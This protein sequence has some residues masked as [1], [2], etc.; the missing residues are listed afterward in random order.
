MKQL[1][2]SEALDIISRSGIKSVRIDEK[3][4]PKYMQ[5]RMEA[6]ERFKEL[7]ISIDEYM[8]RADKALRDADIAGSTGEATLSFSDGFNPSRK[9][10]SPRYLLRLTTDGQEKEFY[11]VGDVIVDGNISFALEEGKIKLWTRVSN[12]EKIKYSPY[13]K[14]QLQ[15]IDE[16]DQEV[17]MTTD[18]EGDVKKI[19]DMLNQTFRGLRGASAEV[20]ENGKFNWADVR[21]VIDE[22]TLWEMGTPDR[23][24]ITGYLKMGDSYPIAITTP[25]GKLMRVKKPESWVTKSFKFDS[26]QVFWDDTLPVSKDRVDAANK[27]LASASSSEQIGNILVSLAK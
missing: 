10:N 16:K 14:E 11:A 5:R 9:Y 12:V 3:R 6:D 1:T 25:N 22:E 19:I 20:N 2:L 7:G 13:R 4:I 8:T 24:D 21:R 27:Q 18:P 26:I 15:P 23:A 17:E